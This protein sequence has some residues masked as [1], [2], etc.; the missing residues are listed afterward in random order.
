MG[1]PTLENL[2]SP[3]VLYAPVFLGDQTILRQTGFDT[4]DKSVA[5]HGMHLRRMVHHNMSIRVG[6]NLLR[7]TGHWSDIVP[8]IVPVD[9]VLLDGT[10][11][12][13]VDHGDLL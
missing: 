8:D 1:V 11:R 2:L 12:T 3:I 9:L 13:Y 4:V 5:L 10:L 6:S 7:A